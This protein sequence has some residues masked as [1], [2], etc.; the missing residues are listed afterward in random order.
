MN[1]EIKNPREPYHIITTTLVRRRRH[2]LRDISF[3]VYDNQKSD[4]FGGF[5]IARR[6]FFF[7]HYRCAHILSIKPHLL[8]SWSCIITSTHYSERDNEKDIIFIALA[9]E[10]YRIDRILLS[11]S[12]DRVHEV[13][14][15][16]GKHSFLIN[17]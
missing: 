16:V 14:L 4:T 9:I 15:K 10:A 6:L 17:T 13:Q 7:V 2:N 11:D 1:V 12:I 8:I 5:L 3:K